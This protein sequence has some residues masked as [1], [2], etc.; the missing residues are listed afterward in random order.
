MRWMKRGLIV[1][2][3]LMLLLVAAFMIDDQI[4]QRRYEEFYAAHPILRV[5]RD[6]PSDRTSVLLQR[7]PI[8]STQSDALRVLSAEGID[9]KLGSQSG[10]PN[11]LKPEVLQPEVLECRPTKVARTRRVPAW[12]IELSLDGNGKVA[13]GSV[14]TFKSAV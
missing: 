8:G 7:V 5:I 2:A 9:C 4:E 1:F 13:G 10:K 3:G 12:H 14:T 11:R 6:T